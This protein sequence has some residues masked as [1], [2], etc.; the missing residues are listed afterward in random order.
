MEAMCA[1]LAAVS[2]DLDHP[3]VNQNFLVATKSHL[4]A[5]YNVSLQAVC[6]NWHFLLSHCISFCLVQN[7][8]VLESHHWRFALSCFYEAHIFD[9]LSQAQWRQIEYLLQH[10]ILAT[11]I[12]RQADYIQRFRKCVQPGSD[13]SLDRSEDKHFVLQIALKCADLGN[14][15]RSWKIS[16]KWSEQICNEFYRQ[17]DFERQ[18]NLPITPICDRTTMTIPKIQTGTVDAYTCTHL[19]KQTFVTCCILLRGQNFSRTL[20]G[21]CLS[22]GISTWTRNCRDS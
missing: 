19:Q 2:H 9:H 13:F 21:H 7:Y 20:S 15:C 10:L 12:S 4:A 18:L 22:Y 8:S 16:Q 5:M 17:G 11:D 14:P 1:L 6:P 3:G